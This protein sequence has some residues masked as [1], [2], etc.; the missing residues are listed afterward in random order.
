MTLIFNIS[1][2]L[3]M[4]L[5]FLCFLDC[6]ELIYTDATVSFWSE[7]LYFSQAHA[8]CWL[9]N[10][11][12]TENFLK[13]IIKPTPL[14]FFPLQCKKRCLISEYWSILLF[15]ISWRHSRSKFFNVKYLMV[16]KIFER[17]AKPLMFSEP[18]LTYLLL[19]ST[20]CEVIW[21]GRGTFSFWTCA[22]DQF[23]TLFIFYWNPV[24]WHR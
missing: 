4:T 9:R 12:T 13:F 17:L 2:N 8:N 14:L 16:L 3:F 7:S 11:L 6:V 22:L 10:E 24:H 5:S 21:G 18:T 23:P 1:S 15:L 20:G 19:T